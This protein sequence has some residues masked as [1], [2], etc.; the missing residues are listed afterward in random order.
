MTVRSAVVSLVLGCMLSV[1]A[2]KLALTSGFAP[3]LAIP[4]GF[5]GFS[6]PFHSTR[7]TP[8]SRHASSPAPASP[9]VVGTH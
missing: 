8:S 1:V 5:L 2:M 3:S 7:R 4:A 9:S 6:A